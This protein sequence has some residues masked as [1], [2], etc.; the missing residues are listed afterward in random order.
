MVSWIFFQT[1]VAMVADKRMIGGG[2]PAVMHNSSFPSD[3]A[4]CLTNSLLNQPINPQ[5][6]QHPT[7]HIPSMAVKSR[8][9]NRNWSRSGAFPNV[10][11][12]RDRQDIRHV[13]HQMHLPSGASIPVCNVNTELASPDPRSTSGAAEE[14]HVHAKGNG[15][16]TTC[17]FTPIS[18]HSPLRPGPRS[19]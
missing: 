7:I 6:E 2:H 11:D 15:F 3:L 4:D 9:E 12:T 13:S 18:E 16:H 5:Y 1:S 17:Q 14:Q 19:Y 8:K 10:E